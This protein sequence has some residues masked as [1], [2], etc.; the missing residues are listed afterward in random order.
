M[1]KKC[2]CC[3]YT[4]IEYANVK[5]GQVLRNFQESDHGLRCKVCA[6]LLCTDCVLDLSKQFV[7]KRHLIHD[8]FLPFVDQI[9]LYA[10]ERKFPTNFIGH[11]CMID[12]RRNEQMKFETSMR[13]IPLLQNP[14]S[15]MYSYA[16]AFCLPEFRLLIKNF[17]KCMD[18]FSLGAEESIRPALHYVVNDECAS[19]LMENGIF[20][21]M[22]L[23]ANWSRKHTN[24]SI[25]LP[26]LLKDKSMKYS[27]D[28]TFVE[29]CNQKLVYEKGSNNINADEVKQS[30][31]YTTES[32]DTDVS[33]IVGHDGESDYG[34]I[35]LFRFNKMQPSFSRRGKQTVY[36]FYGEIKSL[37][38][39][40][41]LERRREGGSSGITGYTRELKILMST[42]NFSPRCGKGTVLL[43][44]KNNLKWHVFYVG[45]K[46]GSPKY[47]YY[48]QPQFGGTFSM[49]SNI[50]QKYS[51]FID[52]AST[53]P[54]TALII[55]KIQE[56]NLFPIKYI[57][58]L[59]CKNEIENINNTKYCMNAYFQKFPHHRNR[60]K[61]IFYEYY[62]SKFLNYTLVCHQVGRHYDV[63]ADKLPSMENRVVFSYPYENKI[64]MSKKNYV[65][66]GRGGCGTGNFGFALLDWRSSNG[67]NKKNV[68]ID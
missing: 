14:K 32:V 57:S 34:S 21:S 66:S 51:F 54:L 65:S 48:T 45:T 33:I 38:K 19:Q 17:T 29:K 68:W 8:E 31:L 7:S 47:T 23:P 11:C 42:P 27:V 37:L 16:G 24:V 10:K 46:D 4:T 40:N 20:P 36:K 3:S 30:F 50:L 59:S 43:K 35:L 62:S 13:K 9:L 2:L 12:V 25:I 28:I 53:K 6:R 64:N 41:G 56:Q 63:F 44:H 55:Q 22:D 67:G 52:F 26:H 58:P 61:C 60:Q 18:V 5:E 15:E 1:N 39:N 49:P